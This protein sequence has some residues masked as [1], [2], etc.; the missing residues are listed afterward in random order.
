VCVC[1]CVWM[2]CDG[3]ECMNLERNWKLARHSGEI[4]FA[5]Y[6][7]QQPLWMPNASGVAWEGLVKGGPPSSLPSFYQQE[8]SKGS[9]SFT[10]TCG[11]RF[12]AE[13]G[14]CDWK[15]GAGRRRKWCCHCGWHPVKCS[16]A[17]SLTRIREC[18][19]V[20]VCVCVCELESLNCIEIVFC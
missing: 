15:V 9:F 4:L 7:Y 14:D 5:H 12:K 13:D 18:T 16:I 19:S 10:F 8:M 6:S 2:K 17:I 3:N 1:V 20:R 11:T